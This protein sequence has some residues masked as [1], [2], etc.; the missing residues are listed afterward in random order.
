ME[1]MRA[2]S[3]AEY[4]SSQEGGPPPGGPPGMDN[5]AVTWVQDNCEKVPQELWQ[6]S[7]SEEQGE[8]GPPG[9]QEGFRRST[10]AAREGGRRCPTEGRKG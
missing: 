3:E 5:A 6:S 4:S 2:E 9:P 8:G 1:E 7:D 10:T